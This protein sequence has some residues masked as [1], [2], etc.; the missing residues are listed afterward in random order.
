MGIKEEM[1]VLARHEGEWDGE[2]VWVDTAG[3]VLDR[4]RA[5]LTCRFPA[6]G[7]HAYWQTNHYTWPDGRE[8]TIQFPATYADRRIWFDTERLTGHAWEVDDKVIVLTWV[9]RHDPSGY[10]YELIHLP[11]GG[12]E[13]TRTWHF[14]Q[15]G[16][17]TRRTLITEHRVR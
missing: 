9:Y 5:Q 14:I 1:P 11:A 4:H 12:D 3:T 16:R 15:G 17:C 2:Y 7:E 6:D 10:F 8:E 13:R